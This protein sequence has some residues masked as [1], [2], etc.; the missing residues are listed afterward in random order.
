ML[1]NICVFPCECYDNLFYFFTNILVWME[2]L[3]VDNK[4][5]VFCV[6]DTVCWCCVDFFVPSRYSFFSFWLD[7][8]NWINQS[9][10]RWYFPSKIMFALQPSYRT[11]RKHFIASRIINACSLHKC[12]QAQRSIVA[13]RSSMHMTCV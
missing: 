5:T 1:F 11:E 13:I 7:E 9:D 2:F 10:F 6:C 8:R 4:I 12:T 3:W